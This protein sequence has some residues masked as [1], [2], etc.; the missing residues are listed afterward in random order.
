MRIN[1]N[2]AILLSDE[3]PGLDSGDSIPPPNFIA[4]S[5]AI[6]LVKLSRE[7]FDAKIKAFKSQFKD[8]RNIKFFLLD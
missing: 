1:K 3:K 5:Q 2:I 4:K 7:T 8:A 6:H